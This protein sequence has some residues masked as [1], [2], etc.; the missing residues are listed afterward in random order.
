MLDPGAVPFTVS[1]VPSSQKEF[2]LTM[3]SVEVL[4]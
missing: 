1:T 3:I 2:G 4:T